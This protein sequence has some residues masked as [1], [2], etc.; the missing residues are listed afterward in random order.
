MLQWRKLLLSAGAAFGSAAAF[1]LLAT[2]TVQPLENLIGG[3]TGWFDWRGRRIAYTVRGRGPALLLVHGIN[4]ASWSYEWRDNVDALA[5]HHTVFTLDLLG[6]GRSDR[7]AVRYGP[8]LY[9]ALLRDF[10]RRVVAGPCTLVAAG[11][12]GTYAIELA[13]GD[14]GRFPALVL[15][16]PAGMS[17]TGERPS[18]G[19]GAARQFLDAPVVGTAAFNA[20]VTRTALERSLR[21]AYHRD[22]LVTDAL[23]ATSYQTVHQPG[24]RHAPAAFLAGQLNLDVRPALRRLT[25]PAL[26]VWGVQAVHAPVEDSLAFRS[27][28]PDLAV[29]LLHPAGD[30]PHAE[31]PAQFN[32]VVLEFMERVH[33]EVIAEAR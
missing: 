6:F 28:K 16:A 13:A 7:P 15:I 11:L 30:L 20:M 31:Q 26:L 25:Q 4:V 29:E 3:N 19:G 12:S 2:R 9:T 5:Q 18:V 32:R 22:A 10:A 14:P 1:N 17:R 23:V 21:D 24:A 27:L 33:A 8:R